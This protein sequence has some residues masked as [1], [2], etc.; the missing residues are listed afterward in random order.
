M[1]LSDGEIELAGRLLTRLI[2]D[3]EKSIPAEYI[4]PRLD[5]TVLADL[6]H[7]PFPD[8]GI[9]IEQL[10][11]EISDTILPNSTAIAHPRFLAYVLGP[12]NGIAPFAD[13]IASALNQNCNFWQLS[14][15]ASVIEQRLVSWLCGL[16]NNRERSCG[17]G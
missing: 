8:E 4:L 15:A 10:F 9:G 7:E 14:P 5:R 1:N 17:A 12:S 13:A 2:R 6:L 3:Y 11:K 16:F